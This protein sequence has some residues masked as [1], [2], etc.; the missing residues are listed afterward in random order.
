MIPM[1]RGYKEGMEYFLRGEYAQAI[2]CFEEGTHGNHGK[3]PSLK[4]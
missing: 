2:D 1:V 3:W 4:L